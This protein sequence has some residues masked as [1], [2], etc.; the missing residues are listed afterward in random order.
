MPTPPVFKKTCPYTVL[1]PPFLIF[2]V[3]SPPEEVTKIYSSHFFKGAELCI[4]MSLDIYH[5]ISYA[6]NQKKK[7]K[8]EKERKDNNINYVNIPNA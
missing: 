1:P 7:K 4:Q 6:Q 2:H 3:V 8:K 5:H